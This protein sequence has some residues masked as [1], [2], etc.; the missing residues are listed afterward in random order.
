M[1]CRH[2]PVH[3]K[4]HC[5]NKHQL[6]NFYIKY[7][8]KITVLSCTINNQ[9]KF[10]TKRPTRAKRLSLYGW[11]S[12]DMHPL[13]HS[14][15]SGTSSGAHAHMAWLR[16]RYAKEKRYGIMAESET[17]HKRSLMYARI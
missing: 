5:C 1:V 17:S 6:V 9:S 13:E 4:C 3:S 16:Q 11:E 7:F 8:G 2:R 10:A 12:I 14:T 15:S